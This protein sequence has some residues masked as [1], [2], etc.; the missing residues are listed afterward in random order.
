VPVPRGAVVRTVEE[1]LAQ[2]ARIKGPVVLKPLD[3]NHGRGVSLGLETP[4]RSAGA[5]N[6]PPSTAAG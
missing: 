1:A 5:S 2:A 3:G 6:R 4:I